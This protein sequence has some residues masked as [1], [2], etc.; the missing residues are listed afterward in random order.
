MMEKWADL[1]VATAGAAGA[2]LGLFFVAVSISIGKIVAVANLSQ[3]TLQPITLLLALVVAPIMLLV[4]GQS[5]QWL[6]SEFLLIGVLTWIVT[7]RIDVTIYQG[8]TPSDKRWG[9]LA[10]MVFSQLATLPLVLAGL[11]TL[12]SGEVGIYWLVPGIILSFVKAVLSS[13]VFLVEINT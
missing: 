2:L 10:N 1:G 7:T 11:I 8:I 13:W 6:G 4:P 9:Y 5:T 12:R 3:S